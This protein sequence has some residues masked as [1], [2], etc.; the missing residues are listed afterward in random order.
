MKAK[1]K[2]VKVGPFKLYEYPGQVPE[3]GGLNIRY[4]SGPGRDGDRLTLVRRWYPGEPDSVRWEFSVAG[5]PG[6]AGGEVVSAEVNWSGCGLDASK[7]ATAARKSWAFVESMA[8]LYVDS[9]GW[10]E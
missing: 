7:P 3:D 8:R 10:A 6:P 9:E 5:S 2:F 4:W 1:R